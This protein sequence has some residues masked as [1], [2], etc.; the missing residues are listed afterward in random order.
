MK[1][2]KSMSRMVSYSS[3]VIVIVSFAL[4]SK[5][6]NRLLSGRRQ[7]LLRFLGLGIVSPHFNAGVTGTS[8]LLLVVL[9]DF[10]L[11]VYGR[12]TVFQRV[13]LRLQSYPAILC[14]RCT[15]GEKPPSSSSKATPVSHTKPSAKPA[16]AS[17]AEPETKPK[18]GAFGEIPRSN[19]GAKAPSRHCTSTHRS[20]SISSW[21]IVHP[22]SFP[23][24]AAYTSHF[25]QF[26][27][28]V[29]NS[30]K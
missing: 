29:N 12:K 16:P 25:T 9:Q 10:Q 7:T 6:P 24:Y 1:P 15:S 8:R 20:G 5:G 18:T 2:S 4:R 17:H 14:W 19:A 21:H 22:L 23:T 26:R 27:A 11:L 3:T 28:Y 13:F 30:D